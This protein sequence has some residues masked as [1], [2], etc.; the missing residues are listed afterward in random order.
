MQE[1]FDNMHE[2]IKEFDKYNRENT[3][4]IEDREFQAA[5]PD[6]HVTKPLYMLIKVDVDPAIVYN[7]PKAH[8]YA[9]NHC[10]SMEYELVD[11]FY[12]NEMHEPC[13]PF[14]KL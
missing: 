11:W 8:T 5:Y 9:E 13:Y 1:Y 3:M 7:N 2:A 6:T 14:I 10:N 4:T 12:P